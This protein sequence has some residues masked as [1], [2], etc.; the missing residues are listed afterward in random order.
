MNENKKKGFLIV[1]HRTYEW[2]WFDGTIEQAINHATTDRR[3]LNYGR[4]GYSI[5]PC[6]S[7]P[8]PTE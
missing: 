3:H 6:S 5:I 7:E 1:F 8:K 4:K 2:E